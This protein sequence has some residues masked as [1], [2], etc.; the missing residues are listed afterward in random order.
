MYS[1]LYIYLCDSLVYTSLLFIILMQLIIIKNLQFSTGG[2]GLML[3][4]YSDNMGAVSIVNDNVNLHIFH[5]LIV[6]VLSNYLVC[7]FCMCI[8]LPHMDA[9]LCL[10]RDL[11]YVFLHPFFLLICMYTHL[12]HICTI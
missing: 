5:G 11:I 6:C 10:F 1:R 9:M 4:P 3:C 8:P 2:L 12:H 7:Y